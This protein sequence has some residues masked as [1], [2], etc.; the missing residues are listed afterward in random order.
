[1]Q[2]EHPHNS[3]T[4]RQATISTPGGRQAPEGLLTLDE[5]A[6]FL[7]LPKST[8]YK[9][10]SAHKIPFYKYGGR[11]IVFDRSELEAWRAARLQRVPTTA[12]QAASAAA[13]CAAKSLR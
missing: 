4:L 13:Y 1:M 6:R 7:G 2:H 11:C 10:T 12:E 5:A 3:E 9:H 8:I